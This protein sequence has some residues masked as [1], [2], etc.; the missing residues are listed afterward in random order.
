MKANR[1]DLLEKLTDL[2]KS[3]RIC[4]NH[5]E[6]KMFTSHLHTRLVAIALPTLFPSLAGSSRTAEVDHSYSALPLISAKIRVLNDR[7][8]VPAIAEDARTA[9]VSAIAETNSG[10]YLRCY[11][12]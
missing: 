3:Y 7:T 5:F 2:Y 9:L 8:I 1:E 4:E 10:M 11:F 12:I 6:E